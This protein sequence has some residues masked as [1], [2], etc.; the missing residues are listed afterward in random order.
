MWLLLVSI[1]PVVVILVYFY[2]RDKYEKEPIKILL[3]A[4]IGGLLSAIATLII[5][6]P[7]MV[8]FPEFKNVLLNSLFKGF[9]GAAIPEEFFKFIFLYWF[10]WRN[11]NL[12]EYFD[13]IVYAVFISLGFAFL[14]NILYVFEGGIGVG[15]MRAFLSVPGHALY[16]VIMG[17]FFSLAKFTLNRKNVFL[18]KSLTYASVAHGIW[19]VLLFISA[20]ISSKFPLI[21]LFISIIFLVFVFQLYKYCLKKIKELV[22]LSFFKPK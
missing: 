9:I 13:G 16:G 11:K 3:K 14:E 2:Y 18:F 17:Y 10:I 19:D 21:M 6:L 5:M 4:F 20:G 8:F 22:E 7:T 15:I 1:F 12:N